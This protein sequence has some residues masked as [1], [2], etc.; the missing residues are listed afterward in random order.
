MKFLNQEIQ[1]P[2]E[3]KKF[4]KL[5]LVQYLLLAFLTILKESELISMTVPAYIFCTVILGFQLNF[6]RNPLYSVLNFSFLFTNGVLSYIIDEAGIS[7]PI[8]QAAIIFCVLSIIG[9]RIDIIKTYTIPLI[10]LILMI[11]VT[12]LFGPSKDV[13]K[14]VS[15]YSALLFNAILVFALINDFRKVNLLIILILLSHSLRGMHTIYQF[16]VDE[17]V[18]Q[19]LIA[20]NAVSYT[21]RHGGF[22]ENPNNTAMDLLASLPLI[23]P[24]F[25]YYKI[26]PLITYLVIAFFSTCIIYT[27]SRTGFVILGLYLFSLV[28]FNKFVNSRYKILIFV[29]GFAFLSQIA[30]MSVVKRFEGIEDDEDT[31]DRITILSDAFNAYKENILTGVGFGGFVQYQKDHNR[32]NKTILNTHNFY[33]SILVDYGTL[34]GLIFMLLIGYPLASA[35]KL[36]PFAYDP[37]T[38]SYLYAFMLT[39]FFFLLFGFTNH[40]QQSRYFFLFCVAFTAYYNYVVKTRLYN[41]KL[42]AI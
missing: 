3:D 18:K 14:D 31:I 35:L 24:L 40:V 19:N 25:H 28:F 34:G 41:R 15:S 12:G 32:S 27:A 20:D 11:I 23:M 26:K 6:I 17:F 38:R 33:L 8:S 7:Y 10:I 13:I 16:N 30:N 29:L 36:Y 22:Q 37:T 2:K 42:Q 4:L 9:A 1:L 21:P 5:I 39:M